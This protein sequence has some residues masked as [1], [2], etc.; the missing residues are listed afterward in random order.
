MINPRLYQKHCRYQTSIM[1]I[2]RAAYHSQ[3]IVWKVYRRIKGPSILKKMKVKGIKAISDIASLA[4][5]R[6]LA[7][8][9]IPASACPQS[10]EEL[11]R[12]KRNKAFIIL[13][14]PVSERHMKSC[15]EQQ[16]LNSV[17]KYGA[18][19]VG[20][21]CIRFAQSIA[22]QVLQPIPATSLKTGADLISSS[23]ATAYS[24]WNQP[25]AKGLRFNS[26]WSVGN[27]KQIGVED[28]PAIYGWTFW[29]KIPSRTKIIWRGG[30]R[31]KLLYIEVSKIRTDFF[32]PRFISHQKRLP[33][34]RSHQ[35]SSSE[36]WQQ[37]SQFPHKTIANSD[38]AVEPCSRKAGILAV[39]A[40]RTYDSGCVFTVCWRKEHLPS[41]LPCRR[42]SSDAD[43]RIE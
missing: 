11:A 31:I 25:S 37:S 5:Y 43:G 4:G 27:A 18:S 38:A 17:N 30:S 14:V 6:L 24:F 15:L 21:N 35:S 32:F 19:L 34:S 20:A 42:T 7:I 40:E 13:S 26:V 28:V 41:S 2:N 9:A 36:K 10:V 33:T 22:P 8:L 39:S 29:W 12:D 16:I 3:F 1:Y 23:G